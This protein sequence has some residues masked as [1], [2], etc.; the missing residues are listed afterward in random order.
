MTNQQPTTTSTT[1]L[2][3]LDNS[4]AQL[5]DNRFTIPGTRWKM[6]IDALIGLIPG[7]GDIF[8]AILSTYFV[9][10]AI[11]VGM[12]WT[13]ILAMIWRILFE[14]LIG[15][16]PIIGDFFDIWYKANVRNNRVLQ[17]YL[18]SKN[19]PTGKTLQ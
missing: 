14:M 11:Q 3:K 10:R 2:T 17:N 15:A 9:V 18:Q 8:M 4:L 19:R 5:L 12:K 13:S 16:I 6:G 1:A 7:V